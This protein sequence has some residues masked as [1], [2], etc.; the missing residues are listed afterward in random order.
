MTGA[1]TQ[2][3]RG[4]TAEQG[5]PDTITTRVNH[6]YMDKDSWASEVQVGDVPFR[7]G[8]RMTYRYDF[9]DNWRFEGAQKC[10][11]RGDRQAVELIKCLDRLFQKSCLQKVD[12]AHC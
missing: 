4:R 11:V 3:Y 1:C 12:S 5:R 2:D 8:Q 6:P 7:V 9:G 10:R